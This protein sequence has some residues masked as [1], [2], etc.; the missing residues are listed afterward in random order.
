MADEINYAFTP[1]NRAARRT[2][3]GGLGDEPCEAGCATGHEMWAMWRTNCLR[4][5]APNFFPGI[6][7]TM[8]TLCRKAADRIAMAS[9]EKVIPLLKAKNLRLKRMLGWANECSETKAAPRRSRNRTWAREQFAQVAA[10]AQRWRPNNH[11]H[12][13]NYQDHCLGRPGWPPM[14]RYQEDYMLRYPKFIPRLPML[15]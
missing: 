15:I 13:R 11:G 12:P 2:M 1:E 14:L 3:R 10:T 8:D 5:Y 4:F 6:V 9:D 7:I